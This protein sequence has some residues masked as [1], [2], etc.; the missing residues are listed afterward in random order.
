[1]DA[2]SVT[3]ADIFKPQQVFTLPNLLSFIRLL[4]GGYIYYLMIHHQVQEATLWIIIAI[5]SDYLDGIVA[6][7]QHRISEMGKIIDPL[8]DKVAIGLASIALY[9]EYGLPLWLVV[10]IIG[11]DIGILLGSVLLISRL[12]FVVPSAIPGKITVTVI[13]ATLLSFL[14]GLQVLQQPLVWLTLIMIILSS[15][16]YLKNAWEM[17]HKTEKKVE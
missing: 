6:R 16:Y 10:L 17:W 1:M 2:R 8:A 3:I 11:R 5:A 15:A 9:Q 14:Y 4:L 13:A 12:K 7:A